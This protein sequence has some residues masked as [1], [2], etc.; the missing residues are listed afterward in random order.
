LTGTF[1]GRRSAA[2]SGST[3]TDTSKILNYN[4]KMGYRQLGQTGF[5]ISEVSLGGHWKDRQG[6]RYWDK[7]TNEEVPADV[8]K[9]RTEVVSAGIDAGINYLDIGT[10]AE[11]LAYGV[12][13]KGRRDKMIIAADDYQL[14]PRKPKNCKVDKLMFDIEQCCRRLGTDY[15]D[16]WRVK[17]DMYGR[18]TDAQVKIMI[19]TFQKAKKA[20]KVIHFGISSHNRP[21]LQHVIETF[22]EVEVVTFPC[23]AKTKAKGGSAT[24]DSVEEVNAGHG[25]DTTQSIFA[26]ARQRNIGVVAIKPFLGGKL[27]KRKTKFP[28]DGP[29]TNEENDLARLTLRCILTNDTITAT[30][31]GLTTVHEVENAAKASYMR[32]IGM[33]QEQMDWLGHVTEDRWVAL[34]RGYAWLR[35]WEIV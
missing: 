8:A 7:F 14:C 5:T 12:A 22:D 3:K 26:A 33:A 9:N 34:P 24:K 1:A 10:A 32:S 20:G 35:Q 27:F 29:G 25:S 19:E 18:N 6:N 31:P 4:S 28:V 11:C 13:L 30:I 17:A 23:T 2:G 15:L 16:V 21:W